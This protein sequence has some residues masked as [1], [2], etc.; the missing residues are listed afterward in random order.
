MKQL[1]TTRTISIDDLR[2]NF[3]EIKKA[4]PFVIFTLTDRGKPIAHL[5]A[6]REM[7][8]K[9]MMKTAGSIKGTDLDQDEVWKAVLKKSS[10]RIDVTL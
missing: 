2:R 8:K 3:G 1:I 7:K 9:M 6:T 4:L 10:R 5:S